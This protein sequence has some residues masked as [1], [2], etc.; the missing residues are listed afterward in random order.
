MKARIAVLSIR[1][2]RCARVRRDRAGARH[3][4]S[5]RAALGRLHDDQRPGAQRARQGLHRQSRRP[6]PGRDL[7]RLARGHA[8]L[9]GARDHEEAPQADRDRA[10]VLRLQPRRPRR[11]LRVDGSGP[12]SS[13]RSR[14]R[15]MPDSKAGTLLTFKALQTYSNGEVVRWI[16]NPTADAPAPQVLIRSADSPVLDYPAGANTAKQSMGKTLTG[17]VFGLP[18][19]SSAP[20]SRSPPQKRPRETSSPRR[21]DR[22]TCRLFHRRRTR[23]R[24]SARLPLHGHPDHT[25]RRGASPSPCS[26]TT[27]SS[28]P[29]RDQQA[30]RHPRLRRRALPRLPRRTVYR[31][32]LSPATYL[33]DDRYGKSSSQTKPTPKHPRVGTGRRPAR[34]YQWHDHRI[35]W[36]SQ[37]LPPKV[38]A[39]KDKPHHVFNWT[40][41][42][43]RRKAASDRR[44]RSTTGHRPRAIR[45]SWSASSYS[46]CSPARPWSGSGEPAGPTRR[47][48]TPARDQRGRRVRA[49]VLRR[50]EFG[51]PRAV[52]LR[53]NGQ[54]LTVDDAERLAE[55]VVPP[56]AWGYI[57]GGAGD[58]RTLRWNRE[59]FS[60]F[61]FARACSSTSPRSRRRRPCWAR[62]SP[63][64]CSWRPW[65]FSPSRTR[66]ASSAWPAARP[67]QG[68]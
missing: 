13:S 55:A 5:E 56:D 24:W 58:E 21:C 3:R 43:V 41:P 65:P 10:R 20:T 60:R 9:E 4:A 17:F 37:T 1:R 14:S 6:V 12:A 33:N 46:S 63:C 64:R 27:T 36:M 22:G 42:T 18:L 28:S 32:S 35:H 23:R 53:A 15:S 67:P 51:Q 31:N 48:K 47:V 68:R 59:A 25:R 66:R 52:R 45:R 44:A 8:G 40:V 19:G 7:H 39:A 11:L 57:A 2:A 30:A 50:S 49:I 34:T 61:R 54:L 38:R 26:T 62:P 29:K 16:G